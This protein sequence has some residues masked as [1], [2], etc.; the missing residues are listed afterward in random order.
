MVFMIYYLRVIITASCMLDTTLRALQN[1]FSFKKNHIKTTILRWG[2]HVSEK[3]GNLSEDTQ[4]VEDLLQVKMRDES[5]LKTLVL[6]M[7][8][9][10]HCCWRLRF[11]DKKTDIQGIQLN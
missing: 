1:S 8:E 6:A 5:V 7:T 4:L 3:L 11:I 10:L 9:S 2:N